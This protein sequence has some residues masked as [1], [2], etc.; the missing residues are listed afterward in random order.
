MSALLSCGMN[1]NELKLYM[2]F[3]RAGDE[4]I[5]RRKAMLET[6]KR[7]LWVKMKELQESIDFIER[8]EEIMD[9]I[10]GVN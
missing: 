1:W 9:G 2:K 3:E 6:K 10:I 8:K 4:T 7:Q 5:E